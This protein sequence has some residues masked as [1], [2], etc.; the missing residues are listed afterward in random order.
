MKKYNIPDWERKSKSYTNM[1]NKRKQPKSNGRNKKTKASRLE[2]RVILGA[3]GDD[4]QSDE[5]ASDET[6]FEIC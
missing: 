2:Q 3:A 1:L 5:E 4:L 6:R